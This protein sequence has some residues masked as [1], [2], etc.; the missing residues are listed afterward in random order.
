MPRARSSK[1][2]IP[3]SLFSLPLYLVVSSHLSFPLSGVLWGSWWIFLRIEQSMLKMALQSTILS[4]KPGN[5]ENLCQ[6]KIFGNHF[7][8]PIILEG[9]YELSQPPHQKNLKYIIRQNYIRPAFTLPASRSSFRSSSSI[10]KSIHSL[11]LGQSQTWIRLKQKPNERKRKDLFSWQAVWC[12][13]RHMYFEVRGRPS[14][15]TTRD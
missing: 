5:L 1:L 11:H 3:P 4:R 8:D 13:R 9:C 12:R 15:W 7:R 14:L 6:A 10:T 2:N